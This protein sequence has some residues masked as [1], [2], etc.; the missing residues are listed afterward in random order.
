MTRSEYR[1]EIESIAN[2][3]KDDIRE[4]GGKVQDL[5]HERCD[6]H[7]W[8]IYTSYN[9]DVLANSGNAE[10]GVDEGLVDANEAI[11]EGGLSRLTAQLACCAMMQ[12]VSEE[13]GSWEPEDDEDEAAE[14]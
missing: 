11:K 12:D 10:C 3:I 14:A 6:S 2:E 13:I 5:V 4:N 7:Q 8:V 1:D 9:Y